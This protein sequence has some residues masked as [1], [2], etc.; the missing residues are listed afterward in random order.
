MHPPRLLLHDPPVPQ[1]SPNPPPQAYAVNVVI[2]LALTAAPV[3]YT[4]VAF[5]LRPGP[6]TLSL[7]D[8]GNQLELLLTLV[9]L[10]AAFAGFIVPVLVAR[11]MRG[12]EESAPAAGST[13]ATDA[14]RAGAENTVMIIRCALFESVA[15]MGFIMVTLGA[16]ASRVVPFAALSLALLLLHF[17]TRERLARPFEG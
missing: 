9:A 4:F 3:I 15:I 13:P 10:A 17:P 14:Q 1:D 16:P 12:P 5:L 8:F 7:P 6:L 2:W 11:M